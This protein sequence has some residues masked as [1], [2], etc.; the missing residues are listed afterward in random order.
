[1]LFFYCPSFCGLIILFVLVR[2]P[3]SGEFFKR[4]KHWVKNTESFLL[5][6]EELSNPSLAHNSNYQ[7]TDALWAKSR[8]FKYT[9]FCCCGIIIITIWKQPSENWTSYHPLLWFFSILLPVYGMFYWW[10]VFFFWKCIKTEPGR[11]ENDEKVMEILQWCGTKFCIL[12]VVVPG[13]PPL[14]FQLQQF[15]PSF[16]FQLL[17]QCCC[18]NRPLL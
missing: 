10:G 5:K 6:F 4:W 8:H 13:G 18:S 11:D 14:Y 1:M 2:W 15:D 17:I 12:Y 7:V 16:Y 3:W 9:T